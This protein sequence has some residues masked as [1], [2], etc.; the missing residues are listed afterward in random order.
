MMSMATFMSLH[1]YLTLKNTL[2]KVLEMEQDNS[3]GLDSK[4]TTESGSV[5]TKKFSLQR[6]RS[7]LTKFNS[8]PNIITIRTTS[9][10]PRSKEKTS[11][12]TTA[13]SSPEEME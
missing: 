1:H 13:N 11:S 9:T 5:S 6:E 3:C 12:T 2:S 8:G 7:T 10:R 4:E